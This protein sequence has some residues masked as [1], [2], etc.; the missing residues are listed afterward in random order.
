MES[1]FFMK[2]KLF[3][4]LFLCCIVII[5]TACQKQADN[6]HQSAEIS[7]SKYAARLSL[8]QNFTLDFDADA[9]E[10]R[11]SAA[12]YQAETMEFDAEKLIPLLLHSEDVKTE[13][14]AE[15]RQY[16]AGNDAFREYLTVYDGGKSVG[17]DNGIIGGFQYRASKNG[18]SK[19]SEQP[20]VVDEVGQ[21][22]GL[23]AAY[24][25]KWDFA[26]KGD[27]T[28]Q[29][30]ED[31]E[32]ELLSILEEAGFPEM[33]IT[34]TYSLDKK[35]MNSHSDLYKEFKKAKNRKF[36]KDIEY[37]EEDEGYLF[38]LSQSIDGIPVVNQSWNAPKRGNLK[39]GKSMYCVGG[40][41][42]YDA[43]GLAYADFDC[44]LQI[45][46]A[47][48]PQALCTPAAAL[49]KLVAYYADVVIS[50]DNPISVAEMKLEY[51][52]TDK[53]APYTMRPAWVFTILQ[54]V[55]FYE[56]YDAF[57]YYLDCFVIDAV[58]GEKLSD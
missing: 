43:D 55:E 29:P 47:G 34:E 27:L 13:N 58:T 32:A 21:P 30:Y 28:F 2:R 18:I 56:D 25:E 45:K 51:V 5:C 38:Y 22:D 42:F 10:A 39:F 54:T 17:E 31:A 14:W 3:I 16:I 15:G 33:Q 19:F 46:E 23:I 50:E 12:V 53:E 8:P 6:A 4:T 35:T 7:L 52:T 44:L 9:V 41:A 26:S 24:N 1:R 37:T 36:D 20:A 57:Y 49:E 48:E 40:E 11:E